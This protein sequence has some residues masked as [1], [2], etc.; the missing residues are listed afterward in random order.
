MARRSARSVGLIVRAVERSLFA[1]SLCLAACAPAPPQEVTILSDPAQCPDLTGTYVE[2]G[3]RRHKD[4]TKPNE[5]SHMSWL[6]IGG[7]GIDYPPVNPPLTKR[8]ESAF[9]P[10]YLAHSLR[11]SHPKAD[12]MQFEAFD[13]AGTLIG[14]YRIGSERHWSCR[15]GLFVQGSSSRSIGVESGSVDVTWKRTLTRLG[16]GSLV[17]SRYESRQSLSYFLHT[18]DGPPRVLNTEELYSPAAQ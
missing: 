4:G 9:P 6:I 12:A 8:G 15:D 17:I 13:D 3:V 2:T 16:D 14:T 7:A 18:P 1:I 5:E 10:K 11:I